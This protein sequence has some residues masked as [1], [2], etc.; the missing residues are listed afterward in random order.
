MSANYHLQSVFNMIWQKHI[1]SY[2]GK[3][4]G[5]SSDK[6]L[7]GYL[8]EIKFDNSQQ[9]TSLELMASRIESRL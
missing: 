5:H 3:Q 7:Q 2:G 8:K 1:N 4:I 6:L 9:Q